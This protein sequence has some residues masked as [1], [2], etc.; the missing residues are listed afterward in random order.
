MDEK[1]LSIIKKGLQL[2]SL[3][4]IRSVTMDDLAA[5][6]SVSKKTLYQNFNNK[7]D[8]VAEVMDH[9]AQEIQDELESEPEEKMNAI[10]EFLVHRRDLFRKLS[11]QNTAIAYLRK[12]YP[13]VFNRLKELRRKVLYEAYLKN[14]QK[15]INEG[16]Y[17][18]DL[19][20]RFLSKLMTGG[21]VYTFDPVYGIFSE[22]EL[23]SDK[24]RDRL[25][26]YHFRGIPVFGNKC[27][28]TVSI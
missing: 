23:L 15:G 27:V 12:Y 21:H 19:D 9:V 8:L 22:E 11:R 28:Y 24:F 7:S 18:K 10:E 3:Y 2:F 17:R 4:G 20:I 25:L 5:G 1:K 26:D 13:D 16:L 6:L 14:L